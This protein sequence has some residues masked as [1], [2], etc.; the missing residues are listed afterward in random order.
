MRLV[1]PPSLARFNDTGDSPARLRSG[2]SASSWPE[3]AR[4]Q[5]EEYAFLLHHGLAPGTL[6]A[7]IDRAKQVGVP[8]HRFLIADRRLTEQAYVDAVA[9]H[10]DLKCL[11]S[12]E[13]LPAGTTPIDGTELSPR[14]LAIMTQDQRRRGMAVALTTPEGLIGRESA[15]ARRAR[16]RHAVRGLRRLDPTLS[17]AG[18]IRQ[19]QLLAIVVALGVP[20]GSAFVA[21]AATHTALLAAVSIPVFLVILFRLLVLSHLLARRKAGG[22]AKG[23]LG[24]AHLPYYAVLVPLFRESAV[25]PDLLE[26]L[27]RIDYPAAKL[28]CILVL[29]ASDTATIATARAA[30]LPPFIRIVIV[31]DCLP[32]TKPKALNYALQLARGDLVAVFDAEDIPAPQQLRLA[33]H[34]FATGDPRLECVQASLLIHNAR[35]SW[36]NR[37]FALE[38]A[39]LFEG[40]LPALARFRLP[41]PLGG[42]SNHFR[43]TFLETSGGWDP[44]NV[45]EDADLGIRIARAG[46]V[47]ATIPSAT[48]EEAPTRLKP[49][50]GQRTRWL[51]G[52]MQT[53]LVHMRQPLRTLRELGLPGFLAFQALIGGVLLSSLLHPLIYVWLGWELSQG[54]F[55]V[56]P[57]DGLERA[58]VALAGFNLIAGCGSAMLLAAIA[59]HRVAATALIPW[60]VTMPL[61][62]LLV[63]WAAWRAVF[64]LAV[65]PY[66]WEKT[67][68]AARRRP[69]QHAGVGDRSDIILF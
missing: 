9:A 49:W 34:A 39:A 65:A 12:S 21:P 19:T 8:V 28:D 55:L 4:D 43:R 17:A 51:K 14:L 37:Q 59:A 25:L 61:Y 16:L 18:P 45:T 26:A 44:H 11:H 20:I 23:R 32:R 52:W 47:I 64:E 31:P 62:W 1:H 35:A 46:G 33:A 41:M 7:A 27:A 38:Y 58:F 57:G 60:V 68:H 53:Y 63:S 5:W 36:L 42:T 66:H 13:V 2:A 56:L 30:V 10:L 48:W 22:G 29:E 67:E 6:A 54:A 40:L 50:I 69:T 24:D 3:P 15:D